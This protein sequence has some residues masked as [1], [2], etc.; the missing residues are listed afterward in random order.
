M[1]TALEHCP[2][3]ELCGAATSLASEGSGLIHA[4][5]GS[6]VTWPRPYIGIILSGLM[7][8]LQIGQNESSFWWS[9]SQR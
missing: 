4:H 6:I 5:L 8:A 3:R 1:K 7:S 2:R 9:C